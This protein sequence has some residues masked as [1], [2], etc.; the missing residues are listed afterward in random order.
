MRFD[1]AI[2]FATSLGGPYAGI[3]DA[4]VTLRD[5]A[6][7]DVDEISGP[8]IY[9]SELYATS[10]VD[11]FRLSGTTLFNADDTFFTPPYHPF[12]TWENAVNSVATSAQFTVSILNPT[13]LT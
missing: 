8:I 12:I 3:F 2:E 1:A 11:N 13:G 9:Y 6:G 10:G 7:A 4:V 5:S